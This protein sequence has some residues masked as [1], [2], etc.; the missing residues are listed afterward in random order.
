MKFAEY[1]ITQ[2][3]GWGIRTS[4]NGLSLSGALLG[5]SVA[6]AEEAV[7]APTPSENVAV[8]KM[9]DTSVTHSEL[10]VAPAAPAEAIAAPVEEEVKLDT[11]DTAWILVVYSAGFT[12]DHSGFSLVL[13]RYGA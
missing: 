3:L 13:R 7:T 5:G 12:H 10:V 9:T 1:L 4:A 11:G 2:K 6:W 8:V